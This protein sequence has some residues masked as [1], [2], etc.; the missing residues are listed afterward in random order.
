MIY[1]K[2]LLVVLDFDGFLVN[3]YAL[4]KATFAHFGLDVGDEER[5]RNRRKFLKYF[6]GG[7]EVLTHLVNISLPKKKKIRAALTEE[8]LAHGRV[9]P[10]FIP[11]VN[12]LIAN[13]QAHV[14]ILSRNYTFNPGPAMRTVLRHHGTDEQ[15]LDFVIP[16]PVGVKKTDV[17]AAMRC[18][19]YRRCLF[20]GDEIGDYD[21]AEAA[22]YIPIIASYG[23]D[24]RARLIDRGV[25]ARC[26]FDTPWQLVSHRR[27]L[28]MTGL[29]LDQPLVG[30]EQK[31]LAAIP[32]T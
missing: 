12:Q 18:A 25:P 28:G 13:P 8:F 23:L 5:F 1:G 27:E 16:I 26:I 24:H 10:E 11:L 3:S 15:E 22:G 32:V 7:R 20:G 29:P 6:G 30:A 21:A 4:L 2:P 31:L 9:F 14:G 19:R 17:L